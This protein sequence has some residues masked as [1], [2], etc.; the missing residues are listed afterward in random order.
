M[1]KNHWGYFGTRGANFLP[2]PSASARVEE[3]KFRLQVS[4]ITFWYLWE[5]LGLFFLFFVPIF[6]FSTLDF[7]CMFSYRQLEIIIN[8]QIRR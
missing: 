8:F 4:N 2:P 3:Q 1:N 5:A 7:D 6:P